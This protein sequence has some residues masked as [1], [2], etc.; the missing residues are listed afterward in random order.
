MSIDQP[1]LDDLRAQLDAGFGDEPALLTPAQHLAA[2]RRALRRRR[3]VATAGSA[4]AVAVMVAAS[5]AVL[6]PDGTGADRTADPVA[7]A[8]RVADPSS[9]AI[10]Q[11]RQAELDRLAKQ[12]R[13]RAEQLR[14]SQLVSNQFPASLDVDGSLVVKEGWRVVQRVSEPVGLLPPEKSLGVVVT[15]GERTRW[16]LL[17]LDRMQDRQGNPTNDVSPSASADDAG[18][19]YSRYEDWLASMVA[20]SGGRGGPE[21]SPYVTVTAD[22]VV[23]PGPGWT[24]VSV[25]EVD[26]IEGYTSPGDRVAE[27]NRGGRTFFVVVRGHGSGA[28]VIPIDGDVLP[29]RTLSA[30]LAYLAQQADSGEGVR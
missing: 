29:S 7:P 10:D 23:V 16:M 18:K 1:D 11:A 27:L 19:G 28:E 26:V 30:L 5:F 15:D 6:G 13:L 12:A 8:P 21:T 4:A 2:G 3:R 14:Q 20:I 22:D 17:T 24:L 25:Q 9:A